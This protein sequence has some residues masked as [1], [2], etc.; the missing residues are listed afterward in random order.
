MAEVTTAV[1]IKLLLPSA[2]SP[3]LAG[4]FSREMAL[5]QSLNHEHIVP[6]LDTG[7]ADGLSYYVMPFF[8][9]GSLRDRLN[10]GA[11]LAIATAAHLV[12]QVAGALAYAH[13]RGVMHRDIKPENV[14]LSGEHA[15]LSD[16][17]VS[18]A[19]VGSG[20]TSITS[21]GFIV[22]TPTY[23][24]PEQAANEGD[25]DGRSDV[26][27]LGVMLHEMM[28]GRAPFHGATTQQIIAARFLA[29]PAMLDTVRPDVPRDLAVLAHTICARAERTA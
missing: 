3:A 14:L 9:D 8:P 5:A 7:Q 2:D 10:G 28:A 16:F 27:S 1:V 17:G 25:L 24:S 26:Y 15:A 4:R 23:M 21:T 13:E 22:G 19:F 11:E 6:V 12:E 20:Q 18:K 29:P